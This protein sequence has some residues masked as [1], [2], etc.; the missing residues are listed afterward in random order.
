[1]RL[2]EISWDWPEIS[3]ILAWKLAPNGFVMVHE[4]LVTLPFDR[5]LVETRRPTFITLSFVG[6]KAAKKLTAKERGTERAIITEMQGRW[7]KIGICM[8]WHFARLGKLGPKDSV[9]LTEQD[10]QAVPGHLQWMAA[11]HPLGVE[12]RFMHRLEAARLARWYK[13]NE[14]PSAFIV[15]RTRL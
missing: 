15:E 11:G 3:V 8:C 1:M 14:D 2:P 6:V 7:Q 4:D 13:D 9:T 5:V 12:W 10:K